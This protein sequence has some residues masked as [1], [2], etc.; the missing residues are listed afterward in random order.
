MDFLMKSIRENPELESN[1]T[2][3]RIVSIF[4]EMAFP[5]YLLCQRSWRYSR[6][7]ADDEKTKDWLKI[8]PEHVYF[9]E[10]IDERIRVNGNWDN[11]EF[12]YIDTDN[13]QSDCW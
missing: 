9:E 2:K 4:N 6:T 5:I 10:E 12:F 7:E 8:K 3:D 11:Y 13:N 1:L